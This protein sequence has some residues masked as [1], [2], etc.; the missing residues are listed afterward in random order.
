MSELTND[1]T[2]ASTPPVSHPHPSKA[3]IIGLTVAVIVSLGLAAAAGASILRTSY[4]NVPAVN[5][6]NSFQKLSEL[7]TFSYNL[8]VDATTPVKE[9]NTHIEFQAAGS[10]DVTENKQTSLNASLTVNQDDQATFGPIEAKIIQAGEVSYL[11]LLSL[12][13]P[14][15][16]GL[17]LSNY[18]DLLLNNWIKLDKNE[19]SEKLKLEQLEQVLATELSAETTERNAKIK[20][21]VKDHLSEIFTVTDQGADNLPADTETT[22]YYT[23][24]VHPDG[25]ITLADALTAELGT[26]ADDIAN[27]LRSSAE[28]LQDLDTLDVTIW[29]GDR[30]HYPHQINIHAAQIDTKTD[31]QLTLRLSDFNQPINIDIPSETTSIDAL[32]QQLQERLTSQITQ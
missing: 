31:Y 8:T 13:L 17:D 29:V 21:I 10:A 5:I 16:A 4:K 25:L 30:D 9:V 23:L 19:L 3:K 28:D 11:N 15:T 24:Q 6:T 32:L 22:T 26:E 14:P 1:P 7:K 27:R 20:K 12:N 2:G 18:Q